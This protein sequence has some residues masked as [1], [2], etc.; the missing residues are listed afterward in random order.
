METLQIVV[1]SII[2][3]ITEFLPISS[4]GHLVILPIIVNWP[5]QGMLFDTALHVGTLMAV[6]VYFRQQVFTL[7]VGLKDF[8]CFKITDSSRLFLLLSL[9]TLP[10]V[11][12][13]VCIQSSVEMF[14]RS[15]IVVGVA[16]IFYGLLLY[17][18]DV[19]MPEKPQ[20]LNRKHAFVYGLFQ[21]LAAIPGTSRSGICM[22]AGR[23]MGFSR[24]EATRYSMLM[25][26][27]LIML[28]G[29]YGFIGDFETPFNWQ[30]AAPELLSGI[31]LSFVSALLAIHLLMK[32]VERVGFLPFV[33]YRV[34]LGIILLYIGF[35]A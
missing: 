25:A 20:K 26:I 21:V 35:N 14:A 13:G 2:Q 32:W 34:L 33:V 23:I 4:S 27:P 7:C 18:V 8:L 5:E 9:S 15:L 3:G 12:I 11:V 1:L 29:I 6:M 28:I 16:S 17:Y 30:T 19:R 24:I 31:A 10:M 22:T